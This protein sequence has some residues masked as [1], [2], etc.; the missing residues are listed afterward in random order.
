MAIKKYRL[1]KMPSDYMFRDDR[2]TFTERGVLG[3]LSAQ[4]GH[5]GNGLS[6]PVITVLNLPPGGLDSHQQVIDILDKLVDTGWAEV[7]E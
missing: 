5:G 1:T 7:V 4:I 6:Y 2:L 3:Y